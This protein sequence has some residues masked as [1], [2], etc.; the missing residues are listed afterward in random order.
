MSDRVS[1]WSLCLVQHLRTHFA[2]APFTE[3]VVTFAQSLYPRGK[4][5]A[6]AEDPATSA[7]AA[8]AAAV[9]SASVETLADSA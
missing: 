3:A 9:A 2:A 7:A 8:A 5:F 4:A 6:V 1:L